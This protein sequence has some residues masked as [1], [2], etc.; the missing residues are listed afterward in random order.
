VNLLDGL[1][2][3]RGPYEIALRIVLHPAYDFL[4]RLVRRLR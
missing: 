1:L 4:R 2:Q 3:R